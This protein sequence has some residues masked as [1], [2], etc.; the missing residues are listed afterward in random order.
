MVVSTQGLGG[1]WLLFLR[2]RSSRT[3]LEGTILPR[4]L[5]DS[6]ARPSE[7]H[8]ARRAGAAWTGRTSSAVHGAPGEVKMQDTFF[9]T[10]EMPLNIKAL[11]PKHKASSFLL[12]SFS[13]RALVCFYMILTAVLSKDNSKFK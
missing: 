12:W 6:L 2:V 3:L 4:A 9:Q 8:L 10:R 1:L 11:K 13:Q 5:L 7:H